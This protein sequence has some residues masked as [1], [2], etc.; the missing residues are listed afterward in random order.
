[1]SEF[2]T[3]ISIAQDFSVL[4]HGRTPQDGDFNGAT[5]RD[6]LLVPA[7]R[8]ALKNQG[9]VIIDLDGVKALGSSFSEEAF[10]GLF[11]KNIG[12]AKDILKTVELRFTQPW[13][14]TFADDIKIYMQEAAKA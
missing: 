13:L 10:G 11:R 7:V 8:E 9:I 2:V 5:F 1:M 6:S 4:P 14:R 3:H 12:Q